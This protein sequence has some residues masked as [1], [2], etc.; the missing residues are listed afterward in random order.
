MASVAYQ[1]VVKKFGSLTVLEDLSLSIK[2]QEFVVF[3]GPS[4][5]GKSTSLRLLAGLETITSGEIFIDDNLVNN[6]SPRDRDIAMVFQSYALYPHMSV[7]ENMAFGL[8]LRKISKEDINRR[9]LFAAE[10]LNLMEVLKRKPRQLSGGQRQRVAVG[11][12]IVREPRVFLMDEPLS[13]L[14]AQLRVQARTEINALQQRLQATIVY[15]THDQ[16]EAM[17]MGHRIAVFNHGVLHQLDTPRTVY[18]HPKDTFVAQFIGSPSMNLYDATVS[19]EG[20]KAL[21]QWGDTTITAPPDQRASLKPYSGEKITLGIRPEHLYVAGQEPS[22][23]D[24][25]A[26]FSAHLRHKELLGK[27]SYLFLNS[28]MGDTTATFDGPFAASAGEEITL[29]ID[30]R[31][32]HFFNP[33]NG[34]SISQAY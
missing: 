34:K 30:S 26:S 16:V 24:S 33:D 12:A 8:R 5:C 28:A 20:E 6:V 13:N 3:V 14:D 7:F 25:T 1:N 22:T 29:T 4:G 15:V 21:L 32:L 18:E 17:T 2:D 27:E 23:T 19:L 10:T 9:V 31:N 11:R